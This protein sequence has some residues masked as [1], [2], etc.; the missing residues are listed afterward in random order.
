VPIFL[1]TKSIRAQW[2]E[3]L[4]L[5]ALYRYIVSPPPYNKVPAEAQTHLFAY[6]PF[7]SRFDGRI[8]SGPELIL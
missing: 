4:G 7:T 5:E 2:L 3:N 8:S 6:N 1:F